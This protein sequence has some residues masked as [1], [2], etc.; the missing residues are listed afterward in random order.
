MYSGD[1]KKHVLSLAAV[2]VLVAGVW[3]PSV[4]W[5]ALIYSRSPA[6]SA[7]SG[8]LTVN[9]SADAFGD[10]CVPF[11]VPP[12]NYWQIKVDDGIN[13]FL[14]EVYASTTLSVAAEFDLPIGD[15]LV[16]QSRCS[17]DSINWEDN[18][19]F[20]FGNDEIIFSVEEVTAELLGVEFTPTSGVVASTTALVVNDLSVMEVSSESGTST[21]T[22]LAG[23]TVSQAD[24]ESFDGFALTATADVSSSSLTGLGTET[25]VE[26]V[27]QWGIPNLA[28]QFD[29]A[30]ELSVFVGAELDGTTLTVK[31][32]VDGTSEWTSDGIVGSTCL[33][34]NSFC[35]FSATKASYYALVLSPAT[36][37]QGFWK[38]HPDTT[39]SILTDALG[40]AI[41]I[42]SGPAARVLG[43]AELLGAYYASVSKTTAGEK[44]SG[45]DQSRLKLLQELVT[46]KLNCAA[47]GCLAGISALIDAAE[48]AYSSGSKGLLDSLTEGLNDYNESGGSLALPE[49]LSPGAATPNQS[50]Q[51]ADE[52]FWDVL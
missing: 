26:G 22:F 13:A 25:V 11:S 48:E 7:F 33:V 52:G 31:R 4:S 49:W 42:G 40:G 41:T 10:I 30:I 45:L 44:R 1:M 37:G 21:V 9:I 12:Y 18:G 15:Y 19:E 50:K 39:E 5:G 23:T 14:S 16:V 29:P 3:S 6:D 27:L 47:F 24:G 36:R 20:E 51:A 38:T 17:P 43:Q 8:V 32:S 46:A 35:T 34:L 28:L 2:A